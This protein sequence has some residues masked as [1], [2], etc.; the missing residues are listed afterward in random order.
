M[1][2]LICINYVKV[3][4]SQSKYTAVFKKE[5]QE[6]AFFFPTTVKKDLVHF[7][8]LSEET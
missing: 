7:F 3:K 2:V 8:L 5:E 4:G 6:N 1:N